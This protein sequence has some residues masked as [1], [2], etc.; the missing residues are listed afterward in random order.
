MYDS[1]HRPFEYTVCGPKNTMKL[2]HSS[3]WLSRVKKESESSQDAG[4]EAIN[5][6]KRVKIFAGGFESYEEYT[7]IR[8]RGMPLL[9]MFSF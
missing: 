1:R 4:D 2:T 7:Y 9:L 8:G 5:A 3:Y 6:P